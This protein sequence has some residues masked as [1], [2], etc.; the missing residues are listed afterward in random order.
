MKEQTTTYLSSRAN[1]LFISI[2]LFAAAF[3][4]RYFMANV[5]IIT[6]DGIL[7]IKTAKGIGSGNLGSISDYGFFNLYSFLIA[8]FQRFLHD[9]EFSAKMVSVLFGSLTVV[10]LFLLTRGLFNEK[11]ALLSALF[12]I[13]HP[14]FAEYASDVLREPVF[15]FFSVVALWLA[16]EGISR[17]KYWLFVL[18]SLATILA[19]FTR[20]EGAMV[21][22]IVVLWILWSSVSGR[23]KRRT[24]LIYICVFLFT[25]PI[26]ASPGLLLLKNR[27]HRW[28]VGLSVDKIP[29][30]M[31]AQSNPMK[32]E[33][34][35]PVQAS[36]RFQAFFEL[37]ARHRYSSFLME[38]VYK[39]IKSFGFPLILLFLFG[40]YR[41]RAI[42]Y[43]QGDA[44]VLI[45]FLVALCGSFAYVAKT[46]YLGTRHGLL[47][48]FPALIWAGTGF[49]EAREKIRNWLAGQKVVSKYFRFDA[50]FL[51]CLV[52]ILLVPQTASSYRSDKAELKKAGIALKHEGFSAAVFI[53]Q[54]SLERVAFYADSDA[55]ELPNKA[56]NEMITDLASHYKGRLMIIDERTIENYRPGFLKMVFSSGFKR[57]II[58]GMDGYKEYAFLIYR[59]Q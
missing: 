41:R 44:L 46:Y 13:V 57:V 5:Q 28:E 32:L 26:L 55:I 43:S 17:S 11:I 10:P 53:V 35:I 37:S 1:P 6:M 18:S 36:G 30:L 3:L 42:P 56:G 20:M 48:A 40:V 47:M 39:F 16:W 2:L 7:Y 58:P 9:W 14:H 38:V 24:V 8:L 54:P 23:T 52:M 4:V 33:S 22:V 12:Y 59:I 31:S 15:W 45:W 27:L 19:V 21:L 25:L 50:V 34:E 29:Q 51:F 49:L